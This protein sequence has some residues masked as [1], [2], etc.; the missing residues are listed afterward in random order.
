MTL[1]VIGR[2]YGRGKYGADT[3]DLG[4]VTEI[5]APSPDTPSGTPTEPWIPIPAAP[6]PVEI[7]ASTVEVPPEIWIPIPPPSNTWM[8]NG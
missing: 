2:K 6:V 7:W 5:W 8:P 4:Y 1:A 3:Y